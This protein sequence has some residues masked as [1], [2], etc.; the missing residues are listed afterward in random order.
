MQCV[1]TRPGRPSEIYSA[2]FDLPGE[3]RSNGNP[4]STY[5]E[6]VDRIVLIAHINKIDCYDTDTAVAVLRLLFVLT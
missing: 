6:K 4:N 5:R 2:R 1:F 3:S